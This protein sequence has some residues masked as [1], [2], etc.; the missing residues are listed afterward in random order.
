MYRSSG[1][2]A[3]WEGPTG[4]GAAANEGELWTFGSCWLTQP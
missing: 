1:H 3:N 4:N 2:T